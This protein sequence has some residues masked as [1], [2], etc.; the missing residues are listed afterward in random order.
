MLADFENKTG[1]A[2]FD[3]TLKQGLA[4]ELQQ[5]PFLNLFP[6]ARVR[7]TLREMSR[8]PD[9]R[10][11]AEIARE[12]C[13][14]HNLTALITGSIAPLG[15]HYA[16]TLEAID[17][18]SG[19]SL[20]RQQVEADSREQVLRALSQAATQLREHLGESLSSIQRFN[21]PLAQA[22]TAKL[23]AFKAW[24]VGVEH[25]FG[26]R[27]MEAIPAYKRAIELDPDFV[28]AYSVLAAI[29]W[30]TGQPDL[31]AEYAQKGYMLKD[32]VGEFEKLRSHQFILR[33]CHRRPH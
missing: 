15:S 27:V 16:I 10:V 9:A 7:Q 12:I 30:A 11:T 20:A 18:H 25:S 3:G 6:E 19:E 8:P 23:E 1:D 17:G 33:L 31:A 29:H 26:G 28:A 21:G 4:I 32:R 5:T 13:E 2:I 22:T 24:S 14:R